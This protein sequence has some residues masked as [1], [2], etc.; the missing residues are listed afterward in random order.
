MSSTP[1]RKS[2]GSAF[3]CSARSKLSNTGSRDLIAST[4]AK[5]RNSCCSRPARRRAFSN[6]ACDRASRS[7]SESR[8]AL[9]F[10]I[11]ASTPEVS[12][13]S[14][15]CPPPTAATSAVSSPSSPAGSSC[16]KSSRAR[17]A[18]VLPFTFTI[19]NLGLL[20]FVKDLVKQT[21]N[22]GNRRH[23]VLVVH[24]RG[25]DDSQRSHHIVSGSRGSSNQHKILHGRQRL[26][27]TDH[28]S[29]GFL[30][31]IQISAE[32]LH[33]FL[34]LFQRLQHRLQA[35]TVMF[36]GHQVGGAF[37]KHYLPSLLSRQRALLIELLNRVHHPVVFAALLL[38]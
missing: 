25:A 9:S 36:A 26:I 10:C 30:L 6:S 17:S 15:G 38:Q 27:E 18:S 11:S 1:L 22:V 29:H 16:S 14:S 5:S 3:T 20:R 33:D 31:H 12:A 23:G 28:H 8:S 4:V 32:E 2:P 21:R 13:A 24:A 7:S 34:F 19:G 35:L 37:N